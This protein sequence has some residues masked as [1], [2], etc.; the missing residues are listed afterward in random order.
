MYFSNSFVPPRI[1]YHLLSFQINGCSVF[2]CKDYEDNISQIWNAVKKHLFSTNDNLVIRQCIETI[3]NILNYLSLNSCDSQILETI[4]LETQS[5]LITTTKTFHVTIDT[6][7]QLSN[8]NSKFCTRIINCA[9]PSLLNQYY[10]SNDSNQEITIMEVLTKFSFVY[11]NFNESLVTCPHLA[12]VPQMLITNLD[13][14]ELR[15]TAWD[16]LTKLA[17]D[18]STK[19]D[20]TFYEKLLFYI[21]NENDT[22]VRDRIYKFIE[23]LSIYFKHICNQLIDS[24]LCESTDQKLKNYLQSLLPIVSTDK[25]LS[26]KIITKMK[27]KCFSEDHNIRLIYLEWYQQLP[28]NSIEFLDYF[29]MEN[30]KIID[31]D[32]I[33]FG[34]E[35]AILTSQILYNLVR[36]SDADF[37]KYEQLVTTKL[38]KLGESTERDA[39][40][41]ICLLYGFLLGIKK[42][43]INELIINALLHIVSTTLNPTLLE[44]SVQILAN[45]VNKIDGKLIIIIMF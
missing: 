18:L 41:T 7:L 43:A 23:Q 20:Q 6:L 24:D 32:T 11:L 2:P 38:N 13:K 8:I 44:L 17:K 45:L 15:L 3:C 33:C 19:M 42:E 40:I 25:K 5:S 4:E 14:K 28:I 16:G 27:D 30:L 1:E 37:I 12:H 9:V 35:T 26:D 29:V 39:V 34:Y 10:L 21:L 22:K 36:S 31:N